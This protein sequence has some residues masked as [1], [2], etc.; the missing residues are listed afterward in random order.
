MMKEEG[1]QPER[2]TRVAPGVLVSSDS[3]GML[4]KGLFSL[5]NN[6]SRSSFLVCV[7]FYVLHLKFYF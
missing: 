5:G 7:H 6:P 1:K 3:I 2:G 4:A